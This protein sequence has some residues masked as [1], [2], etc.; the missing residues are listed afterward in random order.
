MKS[1]AIVLG[2]AATAHAV[3]LP[4][5]SRSSGSIPAGCSTNFDGRFEISV[6]QIDNDKVRTQLLS[7][8][9]RI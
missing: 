6:R 7:F 1:G 5:A 3:S 9:P 2:L 8:K 4:K